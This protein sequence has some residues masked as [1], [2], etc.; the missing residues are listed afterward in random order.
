M[1]FAG[2]GTVALELVHRA[3]DTKKGYKS[4]TNKALCESRRRHDRGY[5]II[6]LL[7]V[8]AVMAII[9]GIAYVR[10]AP[11]LG[12]ARVRGAANVLAGDLQYAQLLAARFGEPMV[13]TVNTST[14][15][16]QIG[17]RDADTVFRTRRFGAGGDYALS[18]FTAVPATLELF[19]TSIVGQSATYTISI[20]G[21]ARQ[22]TM[23]VA[24]QIRVQNVP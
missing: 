2:I 12:R 24:G 15:E 10:V 6:E 11:A 17:D 23:S 1:P 5:T 18:Q 22:I 9:T 21:F 14:L 8:M 7:I 4:L 16:Y 19:P 3:E 13:L 20:D